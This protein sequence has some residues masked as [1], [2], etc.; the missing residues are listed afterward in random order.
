MLEYQLTPS[1]QQLCEQAAAARNARSTS[2]GL[3]NKIESLGRSIEH[4]RQSL[5]A[6]IA[7]ARAFGLQWSEKQT[8]SEDRLGDIVPGL[9]VRHT[10]YNT[11]A[12]ILRAQDNPEHDFVLVTGKYPTFTVR[13]WITGSEGLLLSSEGKQQHIG[14]EYRTVDQS[15]LRPISQHELC[16]PMLEQGQSEPAVTSLIQMSSLFAP[17]PLVRRLL[18]A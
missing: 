13:G 4:E 1:E 10:A 14:P 17:A 6:E 16:R 8:I 5:G 3:P 7:A 2:L 15:S 11:G 9:Q 18:A 12:L